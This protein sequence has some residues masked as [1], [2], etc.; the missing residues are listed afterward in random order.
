MFPIIRAY[1]EILLSGTIQA[2]SF[3]IF[4]AI[5]LGLGL[6]LTSPEMGY[7]V[8]IVG[9]LA[10]LALLNLVTTPRFGAWADRIGARKARAILV[11]FRCSV[12][13][14]FLLFGASPLV[15]GHPDHHH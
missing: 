2:L 6:H 15:V 7:G 4:I 12:V 10:L 11:G 13:L 9:Y 5:W 1:P 8:D 14:L 3:G